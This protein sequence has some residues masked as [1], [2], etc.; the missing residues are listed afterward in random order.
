MRAETDGGES[1]AGMSLESGDDIEGLGLEV[2]PRSRS[3]AVP[4]YTLMYEVAG[5]APIASR[6]VAVALTS[7]LAKAPMMILPVGGPLPGVN[8]LTDW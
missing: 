6:A 3:R 4:Q 7:P 8:A 1:F 2:R 5:F